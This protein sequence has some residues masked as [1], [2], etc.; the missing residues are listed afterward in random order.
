MSPLA[1]VAFAE[2][3]L[4]RR[5][6]CLRA[7][8]VPPLR[9]PRL[10]TFSHHADADSGRFSRIYIRIIAIRKISRKLRCAEGYYPIMSGFASEQVGG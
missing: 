6:P 9:F 1:L 10:C 8:G 5:S 4:R 7:T 3:I 2:G